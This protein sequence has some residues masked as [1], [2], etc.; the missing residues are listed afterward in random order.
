MYFLVPVECIECDSALTAPQ[1][2]IGPNRIECAQ[3]PVNTPLPKLGKF[4]KYQKKDNTPSKV[5]MFNRLVQD[6]SLNFMKLEPVIMGPTAV[7]KRIHASQRKGES[8]KLGMLFN[9]IL[10]PVTANN[11]KLR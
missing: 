1:Q 7:N 10:K 5:Q 6:C 4:N 11:G 9:K 3:T 8:K 2:A